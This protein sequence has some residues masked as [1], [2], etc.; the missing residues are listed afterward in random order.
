MDLQD[1]RDERGE[2]AMAL[3]DGIRVF[4]LDSWPYNCP[5]TLGN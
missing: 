5:P 1:P 4:V 2:V 3:S